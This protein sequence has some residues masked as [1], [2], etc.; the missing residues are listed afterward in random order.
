MKSLGRNL[1]I[2]TQAA[3]QHRGADLRLTTGID[4]QWSHTI[5]AP[6]TL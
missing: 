4:P 6:P 2:G 1:I 5:Q 3:M